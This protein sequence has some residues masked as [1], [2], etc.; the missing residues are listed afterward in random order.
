DSNIGQL[1]FDLGPIVPITGFAGSLRAISIRA[2]RRVAAREMQVV[3][4]RGID[5]VIS[6]ASRASRAGSQESRALQALRKKIDR[7]NEAFSGLPKTQEAANDLIRQTL[8]A[9][10]PIIRT[11]TRN[12]QTIRDVFDQATGRGVRTIDGEFDTFV[13]LK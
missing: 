8:G 5:D 4:A 6:S 11:R 7:G 9:K 12:G 2:L 10:N 1:G 13:N 3:V